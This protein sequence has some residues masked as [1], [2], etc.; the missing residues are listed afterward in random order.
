MWVGE[1]RVGR[2]GGRAGG[3]QADRNVDMKKKFKKEQHEGTKL[4]QYSLYS[5]INP[6]SANVENRLRT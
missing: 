4:L 1:E 5:E 3:R 6:Y 2:A